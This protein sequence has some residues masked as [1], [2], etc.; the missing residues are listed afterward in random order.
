MK[1]KENTVL[2]ALRRIRQVNKSCLTP[3]LVAVIALSSAGCRGEAQTAGASSSRVVDFYACGK[4]ADC[5]VENQKDCCPC[6]A[7]GK[8]LALNVKRV[9][10]YRAAR[11]GRCV[12]D[13]LCPQ[14]Y[15]CDD[16]AR[17][18]CRAGRCELVP[19]R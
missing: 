8:Q 12:G 2:Q 9:G 13:L 11:A 3:V 15:V 10:A 4:S 14:M 5:V 17:A 6:N 16:K 1:I 7:G 18:V 19:G